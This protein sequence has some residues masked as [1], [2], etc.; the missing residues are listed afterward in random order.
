[1]SELGQQAKSPEINGRL[2]KPQQR[3]YIEHRDVGVVPISGSRTSA[4]RHWGRLNLGRALQAV[5]NQHV[6]QSP[7]FAVGTS[8]LDRRNCYQAEYEFPSGERQ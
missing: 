6:V 8:A 3:T 2:L 5:L 4:K 7:E 1:M